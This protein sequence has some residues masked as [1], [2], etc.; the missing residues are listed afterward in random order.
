MIRPL[1]CLVCLASLAGSAV[2]DRSGKDA[3]LLLDQGIALYKAG[4]FAEARSAFDRARVL[5]PDKANPYRWLGL[6]DAHLGRCADA[7]TS[8]ELFIA[9]VPANDS[10]V[11]EAVAVRDRCREELAP[12]VGVL[13]VDSTPPGA[14]VRLDSEAGAILGVT[15]LRQ[16]GIPVGQ[17]FLFLK[18]D[19]HSPVQRSFLIDRGQT[20]HLELSLSPLPVVVA[21]VAA[22]VEI[23][24]PAPPPPAKKRPYWIIGVAVGVVAVAAVGIGLGLGLRSGETE[25]P[26][27]H[28]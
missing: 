28:Y 7:I 5:V 23:R 24:E 2:A 9:K 14:D 4:K 20:I 19:G 12:K 25:L 3:L 17:H 8:L 6:A 26:A 13:V 27:V 18:K 15:P 16:D 10:R 1:A 22:A 11:M 21:P